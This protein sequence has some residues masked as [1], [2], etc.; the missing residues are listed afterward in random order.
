[1]KMCNEKVIIELNRYVAEIGKKVTNLEEE[2]CRHK[3]DLQVHK[4]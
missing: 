2:L 3:K 4:L 1:M